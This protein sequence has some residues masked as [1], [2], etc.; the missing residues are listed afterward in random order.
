MNKNNTQN[1]P[2]T[3]EMLQKQDECPDCLQ[4][5]KHHH[6][7]KEYDVIVD[8]IKAKCKI[9]DMPWS[10]RIGI[11]FEKKHPIMGIEFITKYFILDEPGKLE[12][13][14]ENEVAEVFVI[15]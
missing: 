9:L 5:G 2:L 14:F 3:Y 1:R 4:K 6:A 13:G 10:E 15:N 12:W 8:G 11:K 7:P